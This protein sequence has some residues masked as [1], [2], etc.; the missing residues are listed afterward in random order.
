M[1]FDHYRAEMNRIHQMA[2][3]MLDGLL[4]TRDDIILDV[5][6]RLCT[7]LGYT[8]QQLIGQP[9]ST[10]LPPRH[11]GSGPDPLAGLPAETEFLTATH[12]EVPVEVL[13]GGIHYNGQPAQ[14]IAVRNLTLRRQQEA[15]LRALAYHDPLTGLPN[16]RLFAELLEAAIDRSSRSGEAFMVAYFD[17]DG[18]KLVN[19][20]FGHSIGD[21]LLIDVGA[22]VGPALGKGEVLARVGGDEF[23]MLLVGTESEPGTVGPVARAA[24]A[25][26]SVYTIERPHSTPLKIDVTA[27]IGIARYPDHGQTGEA[28][29]RCADIAMYRAKADGAAKCR[30]FQAAMDV[31]LKERVQLEYDLRQSVERNELVLFYQPQ[32]NC[33]TKALEGFEA[34]LRWNHPV[35]GLLP[36]AQFIPI[37]E[38]TGLIVPLSRWVL[39]T[40]CRE[41]ATWPAH[42]RIAVNVSPLQFRQTDLP[43]QVGAI[44]AATGLAGERLELEVTESVLLEGERHAIDTIMALKAQNIRIALDDFGTGYSSLSYLQRFPF[45]TIKIDKAFVTDL[46]NDPQADAIVE[47]IIMLAQSLDRAVVAEGVET[48]LQMQ[49]LQAFGC[50]DV[51]GYLIGRPAPEPALPKPRPEKQPACCHPG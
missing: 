44:L 46:G 36:P 4:I 40:A 33:H 37:A 9:F 43:G 24:A 23:A 5:N 22:R 11:A 13:V 49:S 25:L 48:E 12:E 15:T 51:Q 32:V 34:L 14:T 26:T 1:H 30:V 29:L 41:A 47:A 31:E 18:F 8:P 2:S 7:M 45:D 38:E 17:L 3:A 28:L 16:R 27:S 10:L 39:E 42:L 35:R 20:L 21:R 6:D 19:D 50:N